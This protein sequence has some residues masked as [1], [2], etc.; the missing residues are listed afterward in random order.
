MC[1]ANIFMD[2]AMGFNAR[3]EWMP[4]DFLVQLVAVVDEAARSVNLIFIIFILYTLLSLSG[5]AGR[6]SPG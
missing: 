3:S 5:N 1:T 4:N 6:L 2:D